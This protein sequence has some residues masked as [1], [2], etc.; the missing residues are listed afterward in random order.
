MT[1]NI[2]TRNFEAL[3]KLLKNEYILKKEISSQ[4]LI[5]SFKECN[6]IEL[7]GKP[8]GIY[9]KDINTLFAVLKSNGYNINCIEDIDYFIEDKVGPKS[10]DEVAERFSDTKRIESKSFNGLMVSVFDKIEVTLNSVRQYIYPV[11]GTGLF[12]HYSTKLELN[13]DIVL[14]GV[15]NP[16]VVWFISRYRHL[17]NQDK[18]YIF[19]SLS[20]FKTSYQYE[21]LESFSGDYIHFGDFDL[22]GISIYLTRI[23]P[24]LKNS[25]SHSFLIPEN[26]YEIIKTKN[27]KKDYSNQTKYLKLDAK[28]DDN[29][30]KLIDF[31]KYNKITLEQEFLSELPN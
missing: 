5:N 17:F 7:Q 24:R 6:A 25:K 3:K 18:Q 14:V 23:V 20:E 11:E 21:W 12:I 2:N 30:Q 8:Q 13:N 31:I 26:I 27:Y 4:K 10:R 15:E 9:L 19:L 28:D 1:I 29:L 22:A 16:Q